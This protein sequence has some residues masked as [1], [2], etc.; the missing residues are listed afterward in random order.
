[1]QNALLELL[2]GMQPG[3]ALKIVDSLNFDA[4]NGATI[5]AVLRASGPMV[6]AIVDRRY[7]IAA[8]GP[9]SPYA[10]IL[11]CLYLSVVSFTVA[12]SQGGSDCFARAEV[13]QG[14]LLCRVYTFV[15]VVGAHIAPC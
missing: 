14:E 6:C 3:G 7:V 4:W 15:A 13:R 2:V 10:L 5:S 9:Y 8:D 11:F 1:M 12:N